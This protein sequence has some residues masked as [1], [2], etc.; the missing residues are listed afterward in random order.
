MYS[1]ATHP[2]A[3]SFVRTIPDSSSQIRTRTEIYKEPQGNRL[4]E[5]TSLGMLPTLSP[6]A[7]NKA[8]AATFSFHTSIVTKRHSSYSPPMPSGSSSKVVKQ[9]PSDVA[10]ET[11]RTYTPYI[12][13]N[14][15]AQW[16]TC[17]YL[18]EQPIVQCAQ[19]FLEVRPV[20]LGPPQFCKSDP[21]HPQRSAHKPQHTQAQHQ[22]RR[23]SLTLRALVCISV[24][25]YGMPSAYDPVA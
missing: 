21:L 20:G 14:F 3:I 17:S 13:A 22:A 10:A 6:S 7:Y 25:T 19:R 12:K 11:K 2:T 16:P 18:F 15:E 8:P 4:H 23:S 5:S 9:K 1:F 24:T